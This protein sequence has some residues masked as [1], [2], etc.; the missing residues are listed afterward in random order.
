MFQM[1]SLIKKINIT[2]IFVFSIGLIGLA[3]LSTY[4]SQSIITDKVHSQLEKRAYSIRNTLEVYDESLK[5]V[6][7]N[8]FEVFESQ[9]SNI[10]IDYTKTVKVK[11][12]ETPL[13]TNNGEQLN[14][15]FDFVDNYTK[16]KGST[17]TVFAKMDDDFVRVTTS[18]KRLNGSRTLGTFLGKKSPAYKALMNKKRYFGTAKLFGND[19]MAVYDPI[20]KNGELIG[21]LYVG[22]NYT[23]SMSKLIQNLKNIKIGDTGYLSIISTKNKSL[24]KVVLHPSMEEQNIYNLKDDNNLE[25]IKELFKNTQGNIHYTEN[26]DDKNIVYLDY[27]DRNWKLILNS[28]IDEF[29]VESYFMQK[30]LFVISTVLLIIIAIIIF[31]ISKKIIISPLN[32][33]QDGLNQFFA[34]LNKEQNNTNIIKIHSDDEIGEMGR[35]INKNI[36]KIERN[37]ELDNQLIEE[38]ISILSEFEQ[39]DLSQRV[40]A[41]TNN[42]VLQELTKLLNQMGEKIET[43]T[44]NVLDILEQYSQ[45]N[46][47]NKVNTNGI[48]EHQLKLASGVNTLGD[49]I[50]KMLVQNKQ[51][52]LS[53]DSSSD[54]LLKNVDILNKNSNDSAA[55]LEETAAAIEEISSNISHNTENVVKMSGFAKGLSKSAENGESLATETTNAM[56][57]IDKEVSAINDAISVI[58]QI[59]FQTN[60]LS[61][62]A[63]V[64]AATAGEAGKGFAVVAQEVRNLASRSADAANEIKIIVENATNK[65]NAGKKISDNMISGYVGLNENISKTI[66]LIKDVE[67]ASKEQLTGI[68]QINDAVNA[69]DQQ[70][71][72]NASIA[73]QTHEV[74]I[75]T[76]TI[77]KLVVSDAD[78]KEFIGK[79]LIKRKSNI[80]LNYKGPEKRQREGLIKKA[81]NSN[82]TITNEKVISKPI[83]S[84]VENDDEWAS[85]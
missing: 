40:K 56:N 70:T 17:A 1:N 71:Q 66:E 4:Y 30:M 36:E 27:K 41:S 2:L 21:I 77:A 63:A 75:E 46:Y 10:E 11:D 47:M 32:Q 62:N 7:N 54:I 31:V 38:S 50:T 64:E 23:S 14:L 81:L 6:A 9:F 57:E 78:E 85:F 69:L 51:N 74:A 49:A 26:G 44:N 79:N 59:S 18:L 53:L 12:I 5:D 13:I 45:N 25:Y 39:G 60:I 52:G 8:L 22:Y 58:D 24:G 35:L 43:N 16:I 65:A 3:L 72:Q 67:M 73:S 61:L 20:V 34:Y 83:K 28:H 80:D 33:L 48:K 84:K 42:P 19:Y 29:L 68:N 55:A 76:D 15:N 37:I 82:D